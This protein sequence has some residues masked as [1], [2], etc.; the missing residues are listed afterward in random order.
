MISYDSND[1]ATT[2]FLKQ[3]NSSDR[4]IDA[5]TSGSTGTPKA[6]RLSKADME[7]SALS[8]CS[9]FGISSNSLMICPL[10]ADYIAGKMMIVRAIVSGADL[11]MEHP[12]N[13]PQLLSEKN[14]DLVPIVPSQL[15]GLIDVAARRTISNIIIGGAPLRA[16]DETRL[17]D[18]PFSSFATYGMTETCSHVA[19]RRLGAGNTMFEALPGYTFGI[20]T[21]SCLVI[22][23]RLQSFGTLVTNDVVE[24]VDDTHFVWKGRFDNVI[25]SGGLKVHPETVEA[26]I[27]NL[28]DR[29]FYISG[30]TDDKW[31]N[32]VVL[33]I[34]GTQYDTRQLIE[35]LRKKL[36]PHELPREVAFHNTFRRT[37]SGKII[38]D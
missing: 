35:E 27:G 12:S 19:L 2:R 18:V 37:S 25:M 32:R 6:I 3:W 22:S 7:A 38:R 5:H 17:S 29:N 4:Y 34:E 1:E 24:L 8:T 13:R 30:A 9:Y 11:I 33:H 15:P 26:A 23:T 20:D 36:Q 14:I 31:G 28:I 21:R 16:A 10:S